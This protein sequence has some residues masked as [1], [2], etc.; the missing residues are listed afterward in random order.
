MATP[1]KN[2]PTVSGSINSINYLELPGSGKLDQYDQESATGVRMFRVDWDQQRAFLDSILGTY[3]SNSEDPWLTTSKVKD[4]KARQ[5][6]DQFPE[7]LA[8]RA[9]VAPSWNEQQKIDKKAS[10][11][12]GG[13]TIAKYEFA[14]ITVYYEFKRDYSFEVEFSTD[15]IQ[16]SNT[17]YVF[18]GEEVNPPSDV[19]INVPVL[20]IL[21][22][23]YAH[24]L[25]E[26]SGGEVVQW[27]SLT[28]NL[29]K[30]NSDQIQMGPSRIGDKRT[31]GLYYTNLTCAAETLKFESAEIMTENFYLKNDLVYQF[32]FRYNRE[33]WN[34][35]FDP[36]ALEYKK[37]VTGTGNKTP[38]D[39][40][41]FSTLVLP[42]YST[43]YLF[44]AMWRREFKALGQQQWNEYDGN[45]Y[46]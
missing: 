1:I 42:T 37:I 5:F 22:R 2:R 43:T 21:I 3:V 7:L 11:G 8:S 46:R 30:V 28:D 6:S 26:Y 25:G 12:I 4:Y 17:T 27:N 35:Q 10:N 40:V 9:T 23:F 24:T 29:G 15:A 16:V 14:D 33:G 45:I 34:T 36:E 39:T 19:T 18:D 38:Y 31:T 13:S 41:E 32:H 44:D 20:D